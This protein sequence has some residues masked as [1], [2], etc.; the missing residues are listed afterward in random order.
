MIS[1]H[2]S[3]GGFPKTFKIIMIFKMLKRAPLS[4][5]LYLQF[6]CGTRFYLRLSIC[7]Y[8][9]YNDDYLQSWF[10]KHYLDSIV[11]SVVVVV[12]ALRAYICL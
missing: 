5:T 2:R 10:D 1:P 6:L 11:V 9:I 3:T 8:T 12:V 7:K 4:P